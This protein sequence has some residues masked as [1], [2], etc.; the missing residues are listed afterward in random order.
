MPIGLSYRLSAMRATPYPNRLLEYSAT[1]PETQVR[2]L[3]VI[4]RLTLGWAATA[5]GERRATTSVTIR[6]LRQKVG[7]T[8]PAPVVE[9]LAALER[10]GVIEVTGPNG[11]PV[12]MSEMARFPGRSVIVGIARTWAVEENS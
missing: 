4:V 10:A 9:A 3:N 8:S 5:S 11:D 1:L 12:R 7:R 2:L 6:Q